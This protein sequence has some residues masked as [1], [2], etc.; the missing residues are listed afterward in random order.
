MRTSSIYLQSCIKS[1]RQS[2]CRTLTI[3]SRDSETGKLLTHLSGS[4]TRTKGRNTNISSPSV[5]LSHASNEWPYIINR[6]CRLVQ[7]CSLCVSPDSAFYIP[8]YLEAGARVLSQLPGLS[9]FIL[10]PDRFER[11]VKFWLW[12][13]IVARP[14]GYYRFIP[15]RIGGTVWMIMVIFVIIIGNVLG[16]AVHVFNNQDLLHSRKHAQKH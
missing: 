12:R 5:N 6:M 2:P 7:S 4:F 13:E 1:A 11:N 9:C 15:F 10:W 3:Y 16:F 14:D 8:F